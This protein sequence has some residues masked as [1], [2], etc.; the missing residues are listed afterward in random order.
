MEAKGR[1]K[2]GALFSMT[3]V[4]KEK[5]G[6]KQKIFQKESCFLGYRYGIIKA[7][8]SNFYKGDKNELD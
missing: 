8:L 1:L 7:L 6:K 4:K 2:K 5:V 3:A